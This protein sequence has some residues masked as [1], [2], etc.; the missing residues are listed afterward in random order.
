MA[1]LGLPRPAAMRGRRHEVRGQGRGGGGSG[2][3]HR[4]SRDEK[5]QLKYSHFFNLLVS[6]GRQALQ[7][8]VPQD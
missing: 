1:G 2:A 5:H 8:A 3:G 6:A 4:G 7:P